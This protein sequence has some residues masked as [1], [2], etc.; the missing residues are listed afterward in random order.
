MVFT[1]APAEDQG[2]AASEQSKGTPARCD[3]S[4]LYCMIR[5]YGHGV[6]RP[7][8]RRREGPEESWPRTRYCYCRRYKIEASDI[9]R[10]ELSNVDQRKWKGESSLLRHGD[11]S[12]N[13]RCIGAPR[14]PGPCC[15]QDQGPGYEK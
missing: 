8:G 6:S 12:I 4:S 3:N 2:L 13:P 7:V 14:G 5:C 11:L 15:R 9:S 10:S 1:F